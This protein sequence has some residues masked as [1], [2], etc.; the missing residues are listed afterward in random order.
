[1]SEISND[2]EADQ[3]HAW[4]R[5]SDGKCIKVYNNKAIDV[6]IT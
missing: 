5:K 1:M 3:H 4:H 2:S 6:T